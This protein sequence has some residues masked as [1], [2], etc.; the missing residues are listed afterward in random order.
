MPGSDLVETIAIA[1]RTTLI[2]RLSP[3]RIIKAV[4]AD[5]KDLRKFRFVLRNLV[6]GQIKVRYQRSVLGFLWTLLNPML[7][8]T[9]LALVWSQIMKIRLE[10]YAVFLF[11]GLIPWQFFAGSVVN[12]SKTLILHEGLIKKVCVQKL[13]FPLSDVMVAAVNMCFA[14]VALFIIFQII[15]A[16]LHIQLVLLPVGLVF[17]MSFTLGVTLIGMTL[18]TKYRD[19]EHIITVMLQAYYFLCPIMYEVEMMGKYGW[20]MKLNP[21]T[22]VLAFFQSA[23]Y[24]GTWPGWKV[25]AV[26]AAAS[27]VTLAI[28]YIAYKA[29]EREFIFKL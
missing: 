28:G 16:P 18:E 13:I 23:F 11:S 25:Y 14:M 20:V 6:L 29:N 27:F 8:M 21:M 19:F 2:Q 10:D 15:G 3:L 4:A 17:L 7:M 26:A 22:H 1:E 9:V 24:Y 12:G 5:I